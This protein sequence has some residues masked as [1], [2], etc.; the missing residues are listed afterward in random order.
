MY[1]R[2]SYRKVFINKVKLVIRV[3]N[4]VIFFVEYLLMKFLFGRREVFDC[5]DGNL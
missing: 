5:L 2:F 1:V 4:E 3:D